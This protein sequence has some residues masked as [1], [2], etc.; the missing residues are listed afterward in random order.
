MGCAE[1]HLFFLKKQLTIC[2]KCAIINVLQKQYAD[3]AELA[4]AHGSGPCGGNFMQV[5]LLL[6]ACVCFFW[7]HPFKWMPSFLFFLWNHL[8]EKRYPRICHLWDFVHLRPFIHGLQCSPILPSPKFHDIYIRYPKSV[9]YS[10]PV[11]SQIV[12]PKV[13]DSEIVENLC[14]SQCNLRWIQRYNAF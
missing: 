14:E 3:M 7:W 8:G 11:S 12:I 4:D 13:G 2:G 6:S 5:R 10:C 1:A 9:L